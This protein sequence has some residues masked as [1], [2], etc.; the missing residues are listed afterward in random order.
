MADESK[1]FFD[2]FYGATQEVKDALKK[3]FVE[4]KLKRSFESYIDSV[5]QKLLELDGNLDKKR[6]QFDSLDLNA[7]VNLINEQEQYKKALVIVKQEYEVMFG[8][9]YKG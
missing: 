5:E 4:K 7:I 6:Q 8:E 1:S 9:K 3:P 2:K